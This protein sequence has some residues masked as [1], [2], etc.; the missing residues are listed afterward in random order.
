MKQ[1]PKLQARRAKATLWPRGHGLAIKPREKREPFTLTASL[2]RSHGSPILALDGAAIGRSYALDVDA[3]LPQLPV[4]PSHNVVALVT[5]QGPLLQRASYNPCGYADGYDAIE[6]R[7]GAALEAESVTAL[8]LAIDSPGGDTAGLFEMIGRLRALKAQAGKPIFAY[9]DECIASAAY[10]IACLADKIFIPMTGEIGSIGCLAIHCD[11]TQANA[12]DGL[13]FKIFRSGA[14]KAEGNPIEP[15]TDRAAQAIQAQVNYLAGKFYDLVV[16][17]RG[18]RPEQIKALEGAMFFGPEA[19]SLGLADGFGSLDAVLTQASSALPTKGTSMTDEEQKRMDDL[20][21]RLAKLEAPPPPPSSDGDDTDDD[22]DAEE[23]ESSA[24]PPPP[25]APAPAPEKGKSKSAAL[26]ARVKQLEAQIAKHEIAT[27]VAK[28]VRDGKVTPGKRDAT[29]ALGEKIGK[30]PIEAFIAALPTHAIKTTTA[31]G[32]TAAIAVTLT[33]E[34][35][36]I[37]KQLGMSKE[38][39]AASKAEDMAKKVTA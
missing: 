38:V 35:T 9:A 3:P 13:T 8:V 4:D 2:A 27:L 1:P 23:G 39:F 31:P 11:E 10:A 29:I 36:A 17:A 21:A 7:I 22:P 5:I 25:P 6:A 28:A 19:L 15:L 32:A 26:Q 24:Q 34:E 12:I 14:R 37:C 20:E 30:E 33:A 18:L 16:E